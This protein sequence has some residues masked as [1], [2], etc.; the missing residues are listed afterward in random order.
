[1]KIVSIAIDGP[2]GAGKSTTAKAISKNMNII[3]VDTGAMY[4]A[5][6]FYVKEQGYNSRDKEKICNCLKDINIELKYENGSQRM[7]LNGQD[8]SDKI[9][10]QEIAMY[11]SDVSAINEVRAFLLELQRDL[12]RKNSVIM[13]G[14]DIGTVVL[15]DAEVKI[16]LTATPEERAKRRHLEL[17]QKGTQI[18][19]EEVLQDINTRDYND[20]NREIAPLKP[21]DTSVIVDSTHF[22]FEESVVALTNIIDGVINGIEE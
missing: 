20:M 18:T 9:R 7:I 8:V 13:D 1:M 15:P 12:A 14:R 10:T 6:G 21:A 19:L 4:R 22:T 5:I 17:V 2:S 16:Y 3:Y 11:A